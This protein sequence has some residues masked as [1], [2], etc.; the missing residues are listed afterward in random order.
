M[1]RHDGE[2]HHATG[3]AELGMGQ[4]RSEPNISSYIRSKRQCV[5][6]LRHAARACSR[7]PEG[8]VLHNA[9]ELDLRANAL[10]RRQAKNNQRRTRT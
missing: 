3:A 2:G 6:V 9:S 7:R 4:S 8:F 1:N 5:I 10:L